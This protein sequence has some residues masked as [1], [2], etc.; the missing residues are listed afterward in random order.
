MYK[1]ASRLQLRFNTNKGPLTVEQLWKLNMTALKELI[2]KEHEELKKISKVDDDL[3]F[4][5]SD[6]TVKGNNQEEE[7]VRLRFNI[8]KDIFS[9]RVA[10]AKA[11]SEAYKANAEINK[12]EALLQEK[13]DAQ[14]KEMSAEELEKLI[15]EKRAKL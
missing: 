7:L 12:L 4:L 8:L 11:S 3:D 9:T 1:K 10:E 15:A 2:V 6:V 13:K 14:L 5:N